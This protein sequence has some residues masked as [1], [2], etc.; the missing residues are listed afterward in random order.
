MELSEAA[1]YCNTI[2]DIQDIQGN[3]ETVI[4]PIPIQDALSA[5]ELQR[6]LQLDLQAESDTF[7]MNIF[8]DALSCL[9]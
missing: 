1:F 6:V 9:D 3:E 5:N 7:G 2:E 4:N 8:L